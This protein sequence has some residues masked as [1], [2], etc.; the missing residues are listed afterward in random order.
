M[1]VLWKDNGNTVNS[2][3]FNWSLWDF[4]SMVSQNKNIFYHMIRIYY[5]T[6]NIKKIHVR[7]GI[8]LCWHIFHCVG[9]AWGTACATAR[10]VRH[11]VRILINWRTLKIAVMNLE[12]LNILERMNI[13][14]NKF[15]PN[16]HFKLKQ[17]IIDPL[18]GNNTSSS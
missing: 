2:I 5:I 1:R 10:Y 4:C 14:I 6:K 16:R 17:N 8:S 3:C 18:F 11:R 9:W 13:S 12:R 15:S 7:F